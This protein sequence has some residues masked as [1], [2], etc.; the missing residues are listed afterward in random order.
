[1]VAE[2]KIT[3]SKEERDEIQYIFETMNSI[4][5][6]FRTFAEDNKLYKEN[7]DLYKRLLDDLSEYQKKY[8]A[9]WDIICKQ[10]NLDVSKKNQY[11][12]VFNEQAIYLN[13]C[14]CE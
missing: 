2:K 10:Y 1:M 7:S 9:W 8:A 11:T 3:I 6:L 14:N 5:V 12:V 13:E 4:K